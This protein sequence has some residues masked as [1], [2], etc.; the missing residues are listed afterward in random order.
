MAQF[1]A[2]LPACGVCFVFL[3]PLA[4]KILEPLA[5]EVHAT[6]VSA[7][8]SLL[9]AKLHIM[10]EAM[11]ARLSYSDVKLVQ[12]PPPPPVKR[13]CIGARSVGVYFGGELDCETGRVYLRDLETGMVI[14]N[15][16][17]FAKLT[18]VV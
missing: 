6:L 8:G 4:F 10:A 14:M 3:C 5:A 1:E 15:H 9:A 16:H 13:G 17:R 12:V 18:A 7:R 11:D 2:L